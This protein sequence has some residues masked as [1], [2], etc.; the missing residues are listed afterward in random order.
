M[1]TWREV[2]QDENYQKLPLG[3]KVKTKNEFFKYTISQSE[4][5][6]SLPVEKQKQ[7]KTDFF[8]PKEEESL[9][10][11]SEEK[12]TFG[13]V[14][15]KAQEEFQTKS[16]FA[17]LDR[18]VEEVAKFIEPDTA[19]EGVVGALK[20]IPRQMAAEVVRAYK[21][22]TAGAF[23]LGMKIAKPVL[24]PILKPVGKFIA[25]KIPEGIKKLA[26]TNLTVGKGQ[27]V[28]YQ[29]L[30]REAELERAIGGR[31]AEQVA[32]TLSTRTVSEVPEVMG[33]KNLPGIKPRLVEKQIPLDEQKYI[34]RIFRKEVIESPE[35][36]AHPKYQ[37]LKKVADEGR[38]VM[39]KWSTELAKS[40]IPKAGASKVIEENVGS[41]MARMYKTKLKPQQSG[42]GLFKDLRLRLNGLKH[43]KD[44]SADVLNL[45]GEIKEPALPTAIRVKEI[46]SSIANNKLFNKV[47]QNPEWTSATNTTGKLI[48]M[49]DSPSVGALKGKF[50]IPEIAEDINAITKASQQSQGMY[51]KAL[52][53]WKFGK[54]VLN[55]AAQVRNA[56]SNTILL[57]LSG[58]SH[59][60][61]AQLFP[62]AFNELL[63]KG[64]IYQQA[65]NDGAIGGEFAGTETMQKL[66]DVY[67]NSQ[68]SN[69][70]RW[71]KIAGSPFKK[72]GELY[73][74]M[75]QAAKL[76][77]YMDVLEKT[78]NSKLA[79]S[80]AQKWLF[81]YNKVPKF[82]D[83]LR[84][85]PIGAPFATFT[86]KAIPRIVETMVNRPMA[87]Y[88]YKA[89]FDAMN[90]TSRK[91]QGMSPVEYSREKKLLPPWVLKDIG[92]VPT[93]VLL[94][95]KDKHGRT[96]WLNLEYIL[97]VGQV[98][99]MAE[100][101]IRGLV[102]SPAFNILADLIKNTDFK[103]TQIVP[104]EA[105][106][107]EAAQAWAGYIYRQIAP[108]LA[109]GGYSAEKIRAG[110]AKEPE[111]FNPDRTRE[112]IPALLDTLVGVKINSL[113]VD[114][115]EQFKMWDKEKRIKAL[116]QEFYKLIN[117]PII[118][119]EYREKKIEDI[120]KKKEK[121]LEE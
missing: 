18:P 6:K 79:A 120:F 33:I 7:L 48:K 59:L 116:N 52:S 72:A 44:L 31:E 68:E 16:P 82:I 54:V 77:K 61:Q 75:E 46:S 78:G 99:E 117:N 22:S 42:L 49:P 41:Y 51:L 40:G 43:K 87:V 39:D 3:E 98:P 73:Q 90:E 30:A 94:P 96:Q 13:G 15:R 23:G 112:A 62:K 17:L 71:M 37:E 21:P 56:L 55:P 66:K 2:V 8:A 76:V 91:Y 109:P 105:T 25:S 70:Q 92:G 81:D 14:I 60:R 35:L 69:L 106:K 111:R 11:F 119:E 93:N 107:P 110:F 108:S 84:K 64:K 74:G 115:A 121:V 32:K 34:G 1:S 104:P 19:Q 85:S 67:I 12:P 100:Q 45:M 86:F 53:A 58:T 113:D 36:L 88:K 101:G 10:P 28:A 47:A 5:F 27:P 20:F 118:K 103:N 65:L 4:K 97:P 83:V 24:K 57:D 89:L 95:W 102:S 38:A 26:L 50:V 80:E 29:G 63:S 114:E 9:A